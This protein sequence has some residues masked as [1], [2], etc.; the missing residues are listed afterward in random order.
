MAKKDLIKLKQEADK[1]FL[2]GK[3]DKAI[4]AYTE[5]EKKSK[6]DI[7]VSQ[8]I[9]ETLNKA[10][11]KD[12]A[13]EKYKECIEKYFEK[14]FLVQ[15]IAIAK[16][17]VEI[18]PADEEAKKRLEELAEKRQARGR[19]LTKAREEKQEETVTEPPASEEAQEQETDEAATAQ[20]AD[21]GMVELPSED[22]E[23]PAD[24]QPEPASI[25]EQEADLPVE[26][27][28]PGMPQQGPVHTPLFSDLEPQELSRIF[29]MLKSSTVQQDEHICKEGDTGDS[30]FVVA[31][32][33]VRVTRRAQ[34][35][36]EIRLAD[37]GSGDFFGEFGYFANS[38]RQAT[39]TAAEQTT[40][41]EV[42]REDMDRLVQEF[43]RV[44]EVM[45]KFYKERV[46]DNLLALSPLFRE[47][48][49]TERMKLIQKFEHREM[50]PGE[51]IVK[52][53]DPGESMYLIKSGRVEV[54]TI[55]PI[56]KSRMLLATLESGEFFGEVSLIKSKPRTASVTALTPVEL[57]EIRRDQFDEIADEHPEM[58]KILENTIEKRVEDTIKQV[59]KKPTAAV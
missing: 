48:G 29:D 56:D 39:V 54:T 16:V 5:L 7:H 2:K 59:T 57:M 55:N 53:G 13:V 40:L 50:D 10:G 18:D 17:V 3:F 15:A 31:Q 37:L 27:E 45:L 35:G 41:L 4:E 9:A 24:E 19:P 26:L 58:K 22:A 38:I 14:G 25:E 11:R 30:I 8:K 36:Q 44:K 51:V 28:E 43:P 33:M 12:E 6:G 47:I 21:Y 42:S 20:D 46:L 23:A 49:Q 34:D 1:L 52:E 32:G